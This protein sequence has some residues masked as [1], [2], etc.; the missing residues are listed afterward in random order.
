MIRWRYSF[1]LVL[2]G[3]ALIAGC[4]QYWRDSGVWDIGEHKGLLLDISNYYHRHA[5]EEG[6][7]C[8]SPIMDGVS[9]AEVLE[10]EGDRV[11]VAVRYDYRDFVRDGDDCDPK[12]RPLRCTIHRE[13][14]GH[15]ARSFEAVKTDTGYEITDMAGPRR[16]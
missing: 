9:A 15:A 7:L 1:I 6:G 12:W 3:L 10:E 16:R 11:L 4:Q 14:Q 5:T 2:A 13:C 8:A